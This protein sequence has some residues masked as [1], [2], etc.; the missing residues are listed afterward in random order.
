MTHRKKILLAVENAI[1]LIEKD[2]DLTV[3]AVLAG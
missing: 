3:E 1:K 2:Q